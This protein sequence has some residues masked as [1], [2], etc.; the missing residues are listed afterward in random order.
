MLNTASTRKLWF[1]DRPT[2][3]PLTEQLS[4]DYHDTRTTDHTLSDD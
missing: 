2:R 3:S 4:S 1:S